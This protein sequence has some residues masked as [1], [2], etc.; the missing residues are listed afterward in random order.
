MAHNYIKV[1]ESLHVRHPPP[2]IFRL[3]DDFVKLVLANNTTGL[4]YA[5]VHVYELYIND[6]IRCTMMYMYVVE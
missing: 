2:P 6:N 3:M 4:D 1:Q 5:Y